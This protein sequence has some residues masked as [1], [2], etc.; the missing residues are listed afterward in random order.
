MKKWSMNAASSSQVWLPWKKSCLSFYLGIWSMLKS[1]APSPSVPRVPPSCSSSH[2]LSTS[3]TTSLIAA[4]EDTQTHTPTCSHTCSLCCVLRSPPPHGV[5]FYWHPSC[6]RLSEC[7]FLEP[8]FFSHLSFLL[9]SVCLRLHSHGCLPPP[10]THT[11][12]LT[13]THW[14]ALDRYPNRLKTWEES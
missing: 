1:N 11:H 5:T 13:H 12:S 4:V 14:V 3:G 10:P 6:L 2:S 7:L 8:S 9:L